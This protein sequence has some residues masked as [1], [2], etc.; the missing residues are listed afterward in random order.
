MLSIYY[1]M[2][3]G[4]LHLSRHFPFCL[5]LKI[6]WHKIV[7]VTVAVILQWVQHEVIFLRLLFFYP[8]LVWLEVYQFYCYFQRLAVGF[9][10]FSI[11]KWLL[12]AIISFH[13]HYFKIFSFISF[14]RSKLGHLFDKP[15]L[16][17][18]CEHLML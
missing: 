10:D 9:L 17:F 8:L 14:L 15:C 6:H 13:L 5:F 1:W 2:R 12:S 11:S 18:Y 16:I 4:R 3:N 7:H